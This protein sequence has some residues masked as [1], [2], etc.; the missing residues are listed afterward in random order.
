MVAEYSQLKQ[1]VNDIAFTVPGNKALGSFI[2]EPLNTWESVFDKN[3]KAN[4]Y[5]KVYPAIAK[6][7]NVQ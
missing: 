7:Y 3:G 4:K 6:K 5:L 2:W 1:E